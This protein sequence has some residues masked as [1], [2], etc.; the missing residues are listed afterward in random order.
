[1]TNKLKALLDKADVVDR[2]TFTAFMFFPDGAYRGF[3]GRNGFQNIKVLARDTDKKWHILEG[4]DVFS[5]DFRGS[6]NIEISNDYRVPC[7][8]F[9]RP[10]YIDNTLHLSTMNGIMKEGN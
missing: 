9:Y 4:G 8:F 2:G 3:F 6:V 10:I 7:L 1:M 5:I